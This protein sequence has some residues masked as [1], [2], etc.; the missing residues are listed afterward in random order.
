MS[1]MVPCEDANITG[2]QVPWDRDQG[3]AARDTEVYNSRTWNRC[4]TVQLLGSFT[5]TCD[6]PFGPTVK[7]N[8]QS[9]FQIQNFNFDNKVFL[10]IF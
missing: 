5:H 9:F 3:D 7:S 10:F 1:H 4:E 2:W 6:R 8:E